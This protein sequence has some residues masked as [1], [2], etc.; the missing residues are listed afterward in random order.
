MKVE[1]LPELPTRL[2]EFRFRLI[3]RLRRDLEVGDGW[4]MSN[5]SA[6]GLNR[7]YSYPS[8]RQDADGALHLAYTVF[9]QH[10]RHVRV[11]PEWV[12]AT[13]EAMLGKKPV[14]EALPAAA[15]KANKI[16]AANQKKYG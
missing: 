12:T 16:L 3:P 4:C 10:I 6:R 8:I 5:D 2:F 1:G 11:M 7:E 15:E 13:S 9:R 14:N